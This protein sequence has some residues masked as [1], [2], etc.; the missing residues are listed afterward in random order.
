MVYPARIMSDAC[1]H[2]MDSIPRKASVDSLESIESLT[3]K[4]GE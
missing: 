2:S 1:L 3:N 4:S